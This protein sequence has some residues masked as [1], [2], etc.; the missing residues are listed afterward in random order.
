M[1][2]TLAAGIV[3]T[4]V[5]LSS[6]CVFAQAGK[7]EKPKIAFTFDDGATADFGS[8][9]LE[10]WNERLLGNLKKHQL[11][12]ILFSMGA[13][14]TSAKGRYVLSSWDNAGHGIANH[15]FSHPNF[16]SKSTT[17]ESFKLELMMNDTLINKY[18]NYRRYFRFPYLKE[19]NSKEKVDGFRAFLKQKEYRNGHVTVDASD[20][21]IDSRLVKRLKE[22]PAADI[23]GFRDYYKAHLLDRAL[24]YDSVSYE[25]TGRRINHVLLL[26]HN[27]AA[28]FIPR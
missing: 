1:I 8:Y 12:A 22:N 25:L 4:I 17:L 16:N 7:E 27:L 9:K 24:F 26:H 3:C 21:Y 18:R 5:Q 10:D 14:K 13:N 20:W 15:T 19:G 6:V 23:S 28:A 11:K 2:R